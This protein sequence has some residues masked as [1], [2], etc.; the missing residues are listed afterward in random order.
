MIAA[1]DAVRMLPVEVVRAGN[2]AIPVEV[3]GTHHDW[4]DYFAALGGLIGGLAAITA[5]AFAVRSARDASR[6]AGAAERSADAAE[7]SLNIM[8]QEAQAA[9]EER[10]RRAD[11]DV[12]LHIR[13]LNISAHKP[14]GAIILTL[15][16]TNKGTRP[17]KRLPV[18][19]L[20]PDSLI[21]VTCQPD[22]S[23]ETVGQ[24]MQTPEVLGD[25]RGA[26]KWD[27]D[28]GPVEVDVDRVQTFRINNP[29]AGTYLLRASLMHEDL[30]QSRTQRWRL[31]IPDAGGGVALTPLYTGAM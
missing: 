30:T 4:L 20:M 16:F 26:R 12:A 8:R 17:A 27:Y 7:E 22:G 19:F 14:P 2:H 9:R 11:P 15:E 18:N 28:M 23:P 5:L 31:D 21:F 3:L 13:P 24:I 29:T 6:S 25:H 10:E 1:V